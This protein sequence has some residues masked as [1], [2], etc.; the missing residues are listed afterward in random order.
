[1]EELKT[2]IECRS[3]WWQLF[4]HDD[5]R[6]TWSSPGFHDRCQEQKFL[7]YD[8]LLEEKNL[9]FEENG[10]QLLV[11]WAGLASDS[12]TQ[13]R[14]F[15]DVKKLLT[16]NGIRFDQLNELRVAPCRGADGG[17]IVVELASDR[18]G[19]GDPRRPGPAI[20][21]L[22]EK[23]RVGIMRNR[24]GRKAKLGVKVCQEWG[25]AGTKRFL[26]IE[27]SE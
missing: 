12:L 18:D 2:R 4:V 24:R 17:R 8:V 25:F 21:D 1:M 13:F 5:D 15:A 14:F 27:L 3:C 7:P 26:K 22:Y 16:A 9:H 19:D 20:L 6:E 10:A 11:K 23:Y